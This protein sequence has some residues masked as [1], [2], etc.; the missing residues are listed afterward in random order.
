[1]SKTT[2]TTAKNVAQTILSQLGGNKFRAMVS[3]NNFVYGTDDNNN[4]FI[5]LRF[6]GNRKASFLKITLNQ[7]DTYDME[8]GK[9][10]K[11]EYKKVH[12]SKG[13]YNDMLQSEFTAF[14]GLY[15]SL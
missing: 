12:E 9:I 15:T 8:F 11:Q 1:M 6:K 7:M 3:A 5:Q 4:D 10:W 13:N 14:T 2:S